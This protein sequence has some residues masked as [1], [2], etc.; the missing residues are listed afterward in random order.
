[1]ETVPII[2]TRH[3]VARAKERLGLTESQLARLMT[4]IHARGAVRQFMSKELMQWFDKS[5]NYEPDT[6]RES[7]VHSGHMF[8]ISTGILVTIYEVPVG[9]AKLALVAAKLNRNR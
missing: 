5:L 2:L 8:V 7:A 3:A 1:M 4:K 9:I 6:M